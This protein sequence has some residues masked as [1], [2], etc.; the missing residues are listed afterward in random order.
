M[1]IAA[2]AVCV[3]DNSQ[4]A[5]SDGHRGQSEAEPLVVHRALLEQEPLGVPLKKERP[6]TWG[7]CLAGHIG[8]D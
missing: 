1:E 7:I 3:P 4:L 6:G 2:A 5:V 8:M